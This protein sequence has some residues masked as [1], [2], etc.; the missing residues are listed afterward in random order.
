MQSGRVG[1]YI[2]HA[3]FLLGPAFYSG[4]PDPP[5]AGVARMAPVGLSAVPLLH[6]PGEALSAFYFL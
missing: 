6:R 5:V 2:E 1:S 4:G 3:S